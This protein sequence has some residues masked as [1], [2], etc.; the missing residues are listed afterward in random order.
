MRPNVFPNFEAS[1]VMM[2][3]TSLNVAH[4]IDVQN[5][6]LDPGEMHNLFNFVNRP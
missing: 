4:L 3:I 6:R 5:A 2:I 1:I